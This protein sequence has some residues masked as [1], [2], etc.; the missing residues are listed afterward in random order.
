[1]PYKDPEKAKAWRAA[2]KERIAARVKAYREANKE[3][4]AAHVRSV[5]PCLIPARRTQPCHQECGH[6]RTSTSQSRAQ[7]PTPAHSLE[8]PSRMTSAPL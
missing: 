5:Q 7:S 4:I 1:M 8:S 3:R 2:N 6:L